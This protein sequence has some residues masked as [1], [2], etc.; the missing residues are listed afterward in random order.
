MRLVRLGRH[1][2]DI[3][4]ICDDRGDC[5]VLDFLDGLDAGYAAAVN[6]ML[7]LLRE[8]LPVHA[9]QGL[10]EP[11]CKALGDGL[12]EFRREP[13]GKR[14]RVIW[15]YDTGRVVV[16]T[17]GFSKAEKTPP[18]EIERARRLRA[19]YAEEQQRGRLTIEQL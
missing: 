5:Q 19:M 17:N 18:A 8:Y 4:A 7:V 11:W 14:V 16:C 6:A 13:K 2:W 12:F 1:Q 10:R 9:P 15:F 3:V